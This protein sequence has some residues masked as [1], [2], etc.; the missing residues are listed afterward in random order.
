MLAATRPSVDS[1][2]HIGG[3]AMAMAAHSDGTFR[4]KSN[5]LNGLPGR[6]PFGDGSASDALQLLE[7][8]SWPWLKCQVNQRSGGGAA[9]I[10]QHPKARGP[11]I[12]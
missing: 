6:C 10:A 3:T 9:A 7:Y 1:S 12:A 8:H 5:H 2:R 4:T 11:R